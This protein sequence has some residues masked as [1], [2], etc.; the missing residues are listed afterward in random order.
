MVTPQPHESVDARRAHLR[1]SLGI[2]ALFDTL[3]GRQH[4]RLIDLSQSGA[5]IILNGPKPVDKGV[6]TWLQF[7]T[8]AEVAW[9]ERDQIGLT[10]DRL[11]PLP[12]MVETRTRAPWVV[13]ELAQSWVSGDLTDD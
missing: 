2:G 1:L 11:L 3:D 13:R 8:Y 5:Q 7:D 9:Q 6:L 12:V 10:F 4:V